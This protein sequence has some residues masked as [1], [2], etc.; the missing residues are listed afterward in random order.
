MPHRRA[1]I[2]TLAVH[3]VMPGSGNE[4]LTV[5]IVQSTT[6]RFESAA[7]VLEYMLFSHTGYSAQELAR[8]G[9]DE[10]MVRLSVGLED[11]DD[12]I[13]D[14]SQALGPDAA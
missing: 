2:G 10:G 3:P 7:Q 13:A 8:A 14:L 11:A 9:V 12:L 5:P 4:P 1:G 6:F